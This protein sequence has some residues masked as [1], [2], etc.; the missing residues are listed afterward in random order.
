MLCTSC[1]IIVHLL[2]QQLGCDLRLHVCVD[3]VQV[4]GPALCLPCL[5]NVL[6]LVTLVVSFLFG[7]PH[8]RFCGTGWNNIC[9]S[10]LILSEVICYLL[11]N[12]R[13]MHLSSQWNC[14]QTPIN[15]A[16]PLLYSKCGTESTHT[17]FKVLKPI[18][19]IC[20]TATNSGLTG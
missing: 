17:Q 16:T 12:I 1:H 10:T 19:L 3:L 2:M 4:F 9:Q 11:V 7:F 14:W 18:W 5:C 20:V 8:V 6:L 13:S 15:S